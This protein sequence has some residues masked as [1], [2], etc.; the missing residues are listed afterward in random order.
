MS[1]LYTG[2]FFFSPHF[3][4]SQKNIYYV[5][6]KL[7][8]WFK[9]KRKMSIITLRLCLSTLKIWFYFSMST[10]FSSLPGAIF[11]NVFYN[12]IC[13]WQISFICHF[14]NAIFGG[15]STEGEQKPKLL[16]PP[17]GLQ[18]QFFCIQ[19]TYLRVF[20]PTKSQDLI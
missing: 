12:K 8:L 18:I 10:H 19:S 13:V 4:F 2:V 11:K 6:C 5:S 7:I 9:T 16:P 3:N 14:S 1:V 15:F 20:K 17:L